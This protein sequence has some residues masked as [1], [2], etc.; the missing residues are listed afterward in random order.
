MGKY[1][2]ILKRPWIGIVPTLS[3]LIILLIP[4]QKRYHKI[5]NSFSKSLMQSVPDIPFYFDK[6]LCYYITDILGI[7]LFSILLIQGRIK[8][9]ELILQSTTKYLSLFIALCFCS[10]YLAKSAPFQYFQLL[11][12]SCAILFFYSLISYF[13][14]N[15]KIFINRACIIILIVALFECAVGISQYFLQHHL[16]LK[17]I[18]EAYFGNFPYPAS[19]PMSDGSKW[20]ID[21]FLNH[22]IEQ[23]NI[24][25][26]F[27]TFAHPNIFGGF[28]VF[29]LISTYYVF[30]S[31]TSKKMQALV[32]FSIFIQLFTLCLT[33]SRAA[34]I[35]W[36]LSTVL[37]AFL[38]F[39]K[40]DLKLRLSKLYPLALSVTLSIALSALLLYPQFLQRGGIVNYTDF[41]AAGDA[42]R[43]AFQNTA[44][45]MIKSHPMLGVGFNNFL[46]KMPEFAPK[47][48][49]EGYYSMPH[50]IYFFIGAETGLLGVIA[51]FLFLFALVAPSLKQDLNPATSTFLCLLV[52]LLFIGACDFYPLYSQQ[53]RMLFF[54][55]CA[56][57]ML[58]YEL[59]E[60]KGQLVPE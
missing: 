40:S 5:L 29:S 53:G 13:K 45:E 30:F 48:L 8:L 27:G 35:G 55:T 33:Y 32:G 46:L 37:W 11:H 24:I 19:F 52:G 49:P 39:L 47:E 38:L 14:E 31:L 3:L 17:Q 36:V 21:R 6:H 44:L 56:L 50:N 1:L 54:T 7:L 28:L 25:R 4:L 51:F 9:K 15:P 41:N 18:G 60:R 59:K 22:S 34:L 58:S 20:I 26:S 10:I 16:G 42:N 57:L 23:K 2:A 12:F 43:L